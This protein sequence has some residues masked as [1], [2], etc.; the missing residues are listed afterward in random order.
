[1]PL[2]LPVWQGEARAQDE[3][4]P[5]PRQRYAALLKDLATQR[6]ELIPAI[7]KAKGD[8]QK[9]LIQKYTGLGKEFAE[10]FYKLAEDAPKDAV[11]TDALFWVLQNGTGSPVYQKSLEKVTALVEA[12]PLKDLAP[13]LNAVR[14]ANFRLLESVLARAE[15]DESD[16]QAADLLA[17]IATN[18][19]A[20]PLGKKATERLVQKHSDHPAVEKLCQV[21][22]N[23][24]ST[25]AA[26]TL[27]EI[28]EKGT[29]PGVKA[30][31][32]L[33]LGKR[34]AAQ[35]IDL[36]DKIAEADKVA[37]EAEKYLAKAI[38]LVGADNPAM[39]KEAEKELKA[40]R[41]LRVGK[42]APEITATDLDEKEFK[43]SDY[44]GKVVLLDFW[45]NW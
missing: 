37:A 24:R 39:K 3:K 42:E 21:L 22:T 19:G 40:L 29:K 26:D 41:T 31:A 23:N 15:K 28:L 45:G 5:P 10:K 25:Q 32:S 8:E 34:L 16:P 36:G 35:A 4:E 33:G 2:A 43:L 30:A 12:M 18:G 9:K 1:L 14:M 44:R 11:A 20:T 27:K 17:W 38:D 13:R 7:N 6:N